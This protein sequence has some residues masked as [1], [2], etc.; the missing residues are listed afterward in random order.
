M[1][2]ETPRDPIAPPG[3]GPPEW[4]EERLR[5]QV[6]RFVRDRVGYDCETSLTSTQVKEALALSEDEV[7]R[8]VGWLHEH[9]YLRLVGARPSVCIT[10][11]AIQYLDIVAA[12]RQSLRG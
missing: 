9:G 6:I 10:P 5:Y 12:R 7:G 2:P 11:Q 3:M 8:T 4:H 1:N